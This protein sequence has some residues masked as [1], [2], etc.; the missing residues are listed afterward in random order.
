MQVIEWSRF[1]ADGLPLGGKSSAMA[2]GV[3]DGVHRGHRAL[4]QRIVSHDAGETPVAITFRQNHKKA[5]D[6]MSFRQKLA[7]FEKLGVALTVVIEFSESFRRMPGVEFLRILLEH[8]SLGFL[9]VGG[10]FRCGYRLDT[11]AGDIQQFTGARGIPA[12]IVEPLWEGSAPI[13]SSR[14]RAA[15]R[16][17]RLDEAALLLGCPFTLD[18]SGAEQAQ[19][20]DEMVYAIECLGLVL[21]P[22]GRYPVLLY[23]KNGETQTA[24]I[25]LERGNIHIP[26]AAMEQPF[27]GGRW[28]YIEFDISPEGAQGRAV[29]R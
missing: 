18:I 6:I 7:A 3:F 10:N 27:P 24:E 19:R 29:C 16:A 23:A 22:P 25:Q 26:T 1:L 20:D 17:G 5:G 11:G 13:S 8:G 28:E 2:I 14:I 9:A 21:P 12:D 15:I 4:I